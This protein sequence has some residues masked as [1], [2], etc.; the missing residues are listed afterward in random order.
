MNRPDWPDVKGLGMALVISLLCQCETRTNRLPFPGWFWNICNKSRILNQTVTLL[1]GKVIL[2][3]AIFP[4]DIPPHMYLL[5]LWT[6]NL[7]PITHTPSLSTA[8]SSPFLPSWSC[9]CGE[10]GSGEPQASLHLT[11]QIDNS[12]SLHCLLVANMTIS[13]TVTNSRITECN[14]ISV[15]LFFSLVYGYTNC[16]YQICQ[17]AYCMCFKCEEYQQCTRM[18]LLWGLWGLKL[19]VKPKRFVC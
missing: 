4:E 7:T 3:K 8:V 2:I 6:P 19:S 13:V 12:M 16:D 1:A 11:T 10:G 9:G 5:L 17:N 14:F 18:G 15:G